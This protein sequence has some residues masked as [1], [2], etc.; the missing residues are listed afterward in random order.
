MAGR[1][2]KRRARDITE[3]CFE[4]EGRCGQ[5]SFVVVEF[6]SGMPMKGKGWPWI[7]A[8][9]RGVLGEEKAEKVSF[10]G[11]KLLVKTV[12]E[13]QTEKL[14]CVKQMG[15]QMVKVK[16]HEK[17]NESKG[18]IY[19][20]DLMDLEEQDVVD[21]LKEYGVR[22]AKQ[23][24]RKVGNREVKTP[25]FVLTFD[26]M[27]PPSRIQMDYSSYP[28][29]RSYPKPRQCLSC[30]K[31]GHTFHM[32][33]APATC[34]RCGKGKHGTGH[35]TCDMNCVNCG[36]A[37]HVS[38]NNVCPAYKDELEIMKVKVDRCIPYTEARRE[39]LKGRD[40]SGTSFSSA[41]TRS[42][43]NSMVGGIGE[44]LEKVEKC[45]ESVVELLKELMRTK[46]AEKSGS[47]EVRES[48]TTEQTE[49][50]ESV[51][52]EKQAEV[53]QGSSEGE[54]QVEQARTDE[55][56]QSSQEEE[57]PPNQEK[58][59]PWLTAKNL[60]GGS[61]R[62]QA[63]GRLSPN[64]RVSHGSSQESSQD[65]TYCDTGPQFFSSRTLE[66]LDRMHTEEIYNT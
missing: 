6:E 30:G 12:H 64:G 35:L 19:A 31:L 37:D 20:E 29:R 56:I 10:L 32:C 16:K 43:G 53:R 57:I 45:L 18:T 21:G 51:A 42:A 17:L 13:N 15:G 33:Q 46:V 8:G 22:E 23:I 3:E 25:L 14:L 27:V 60:R 63:G 28:V 55:V 24:K 52:T 4:R 48:V 65:H 34:L 36:K 66:E 54:D 38:L 39:V 49:V 58:G 50:R 9:L 11:D 2:S 47:E 62:R 1:P 61:G 59:G 44:R 41:V 5:G 7:Q 26:L 40:V